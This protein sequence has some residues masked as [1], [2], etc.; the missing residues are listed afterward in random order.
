MSVRNRIEAEL[1]ARFQ[2]DRLEVINE[3]HHHAGHQPGM[4]G[5]GESHMRVRIVS[6]QFSGLSRLERHRL[7]NAALKPELDA[8][9]HALA[10][11]AAAP[12]EATRW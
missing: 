1:T 9:L 10:V 8:G 7:V 5:S 2:P 11:E 3:S 4:D 6:A 12:G